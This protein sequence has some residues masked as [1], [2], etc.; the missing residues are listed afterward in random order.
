MSFSFGYPAFPPLS[1]SGCL[2]YRREPAICGGSKSLEETSDILI[3]PILE[4]CLWQCGHRERLRARR[5]NSSTFVATR[6]DLGKEAGKLMLK[7]LPNGGKCVGFVGLPGA[8]NARERIEGDQTR[9][10]HMSYDLL[11]TL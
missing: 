8:D 9:A 4:N 11:R 7:A 5:S 10:K 3:K 2:A 1:I 6:S